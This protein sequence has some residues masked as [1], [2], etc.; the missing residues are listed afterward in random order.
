LL[1]TLANLYTLPEYRSRIVGLLIPGIAPVS[2]ITQMILDRSNIP[3]MRSE[4]HTTAELYRII[5]EDVSKIIA[6]DTEKLEVIKG[7]AESHIDFD[8]LDR[9]FST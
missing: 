2:N 4:E 7:L 8:L 3:Y 1:V 6:A 5:T 9:I